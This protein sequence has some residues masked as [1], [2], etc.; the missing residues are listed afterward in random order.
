MKKIIFTFSLV[1]SVAVFSQ[2]NAQTTNCTPEQ[3]E[4]CKKI[5]KTIPANCIAVTQAV[6]EKKTCSPAKKAS[7]ASTEATSIFASFLN[8]G[9]NTKATSCNPAP[10]CNKSVQSVKLAKNEKPSC[11]AAK[12]KVAMASTEE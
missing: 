9:T 4:A 12:P 7:T 11:T 1:L 6:A 10:G 2:V 8:F 5:C 3:I